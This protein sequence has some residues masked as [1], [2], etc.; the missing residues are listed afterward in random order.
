ME[1]MLHEN[2]KNIAIITSNLY[3]GGAEKIAAM[4]SDYLTERG[5]NVYLFLDHFYGYKEYHYSGRVVRMR[6]VKTGNDWFDMYYK[7]QHLKKMK[8][9][10]KIH[11]SFSLME[12]YNFINVL[13][14][15]DDTTVLSVH[16]YLTLLYKNPNYIKDKKRHHVLITLLYNCADNVI[17]L[18]EIAKKDL[19][20]NFFVKKNKIQCIPNP[21]DERKYSISSKKLPE[22]SIVMIG[23]MAEA[24]AQ[25]YMI[26]AMK[27]VLVKV[28]DAHL[29]LLGEGP[30]MGALKQVASNLGIADNVHFEGFQ[31][32][33]YAYLNA[34]KL[35]AHVSSHEGFSL[36]ILDALA[37]GVP[38][39]CSDHISGSRDILAP[40]TSYD[41]RLIKAE[42]AE[43]GILVPCPDDS[44]TNLSPVLTKNENCLAKVVVE[45]LTDD[46]LREHYA[47]QSKKRALAFSQ[48]YVLGEWEKLIP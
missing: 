28:A 34:A 7:A 8:Q 13:S 17:A 4:L 21:I 46:K 3:N 39:V 43:Y 6:A 27:G 16:N 14:K 23:R 1:I 38:V 2:K 30:L 29:Y 22:N 12:E 24:K 5:Y 31:E 26:R 36:A 40:G 44:I 19:S 20:D 11:C 18:T 42:R 45:M 32:D 25:W 9:K 41:K 33:V 35:Y 37:C 10:L 15:V 48:D 47:S